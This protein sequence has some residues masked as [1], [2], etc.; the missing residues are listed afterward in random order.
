[1]DENSNSSNVSKKPSL[2]FFSKMHKG[3][4]RMYTWEEAVSINA[5]LDFVL[6]MARQAPIME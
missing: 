2:N 1:M 3:K 5:K 4:K 6:L